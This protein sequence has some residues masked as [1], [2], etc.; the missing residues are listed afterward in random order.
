MDVAPKATCCHDWPLLAA[1]SCRHPHSPLVPVCWGQFIHMASSLFPLTR[2]TSGHA[3]QRMSGDRSHLATGHSVARRPPY[4]GRSIGQEGG[5]PQAEAGVLRSAGLQE[6]LGLMGRR[7]PP[8]PLL[9]LLSWPDRV[10][11]FSCSPL[12]PSSTSRGPARPVCGGGRT[13]GLGG[14]WAQGAQS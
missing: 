8:H 14:A 9:S 1:L 6:A 7:A 2:V 11:R 12:S 10:A 3:L 4:I 13:Q 5:G